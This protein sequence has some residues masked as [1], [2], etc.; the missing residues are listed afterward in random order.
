MLAIADASTPLRP[1]PKLIGAGL[2]AFAALEAASILQWLA[3]PQ[4]PPFDDFFG[5]WSFGKFA[6]AAGPAI[7]NPAALQAFQHMLDP[8]F[9]GGYPYPYPPTFAL[10]LAPLG[11]LPLGAAYA[12]WICGTFAI[13]ALVTLRGDWRSLYGLALVA[14]P[15]TLITVVS[16]QNG[17]VSA[18]LLA[19]GLSCLK[20]SPIASGILLGL[21]AYKPQLGILVPVV[22]LASRQW[23]ATLSACLTV[24]A[25]VIASSTEFGWFIWLDWL[26][27]M[28]LYWDAL[29]VNQAHLLHL[30]P[31][32]LA[33]MTELGVPK[34]MGYAA[35]M[36]V[37]AVLA[38]IV[39]R[40]AS[41]ALDERCVAAAIAATALATPYAFTYDM[42]MLT[43][44]LVIAARMRQRCGNPVQIWEIAVVVL[45]FAVLM[46]MTGH[47]LPLVAP[48]LMGIV[49]CT[50]AVTKHGS[51]HHVSKAWMV[52]LRAP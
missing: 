3:G 23:R 43:A 42:P 45:L 49:F 18:A 50:I 1:H 32:V 47:A 27:D 15:T 19:G 52:R 34:P 38:V 17:F 44:A 37:A 12:L 2:L 10:V 5:L 46:G 31:T 30:M 39:W 48:T 26:R 20:R 36:L 21:L 6:A 7:Y 35:Q 16:G 40:L 14:A 51:P 28:P 11:M 33:G 41:R 13:Y 9:S 25:A 22:L 24:L 8:A 29:R 4:M